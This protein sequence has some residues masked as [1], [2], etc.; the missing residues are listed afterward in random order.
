MARDLRVGKGKLY[1]DD[2]K[3]N[4]RF[5]FFDDCDPV[6]S[7]C[8]KDMGSCWVCSVCKE[9]YCYD[10]VTDHKSACKCYLRNY[11]HIWYKSSW[12][13]EKNAR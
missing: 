11:E 9:A 5:I 2:D 13:K 10:C 4:H 7:N 1:I 12:G 3:G 8:K 6:C